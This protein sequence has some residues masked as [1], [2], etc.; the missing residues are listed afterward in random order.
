MGKSAVVGLVAGA[1]GSGISGATNSLAKEAVS[2][3]GRVVIGVVGGG[4]GGAIAGGGT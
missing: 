3:G 2:K 1:A 4:A